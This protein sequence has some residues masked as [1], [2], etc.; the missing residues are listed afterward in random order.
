M[1]DL[2]VQGGRVVT[3]DGVQRADL[4]VQ[5]GRIVAIGE[6]LGPATEVLDARN[7]LVLPGGVDSHCH[8]DQPPW[9]GM[10]TAD[11]F[12]SATL[13]A[14]CGGTTT[15]I[16]FA[17]QLRGQSLR[18]CVADYHRRA[19]G[20]AH[21]DYA[22]HLI[23]GDPSPE[24]LEHEL[25]A[26]MA[27]GCT[28]LKLYMTYEGL[29]LDDDEVLQTLDTARRLGALAMVHAENDAA[30][31]FL[32]HRL[33][34]SGRTA[35]R[36]HARA[37]PALGDREAAHRAITFAELVEA[38]ILIAHVS[39]AEVVEEIRRA[40]ARGAPILA[41]TCPQYLF[42]SEADLAGPGVEGAKCVCTPPPRTR[43]DQEAVYAGL[44]DGALAVF[45]SDH[46]PWRFTDKVAEGPA[47]PFHHV[48]NGIPGIETRLALLFSDAVRAGRMSLT[49]FAERTAAAPARLF[50]L[51]PRKG[52]LT[53]G[54]DADLVLWDPDREVTITNSLLH[55]AIDYT[56][57]EGRRL[58]GWPATTV[59]R[60]EVV[61]HEGQARSVAGRGNFLSCARPFAPISA[62]QSWLAR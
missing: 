54:A 32:T 59:A 6:D 51:A 53:A 31:R 44:L 47:T 42:L 17:M 15:V 27:E 60:G 41:E 30:V 20:R 2:L 13:S 23:I 55:H 9:Q 4:S 39:A 11:D 18:D 46:S 24:V 1:L 16:P 26:L 38:P 10:T 57:Y 12:A 43:R 48:P 7:R 19:A 29:R 8:M 45:S 3:P 21:I 5:S 56:P 61:W 62:P 58:R 52:A 14:L 28:S 40:Q 22:F 34:S 25:P 49:D 33:V 50:G 35:M 36:Y 37:R